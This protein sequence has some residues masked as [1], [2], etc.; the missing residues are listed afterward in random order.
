[1]SLDKIE[2]RDRWAVARVGKYITISRAEKDTGNAVIS[3]RDPHPGC[4]WTLIG[5]GPDDQQNALAEVICDALNAAAV[6]S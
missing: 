5:A 4:Y 6:L 2:A 3:P 1:M